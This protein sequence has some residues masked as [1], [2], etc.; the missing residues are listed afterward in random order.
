M[1]NNLY[2]FYRSKEWESF[3]KVVIAERV[4]EDGFVYD[5]VTGKPIVKAY[6]IILH[7]KIE[8]TEENIFDFSISLNPDNIMIVSHKTH[9]LIHNK[10]GYGMREVFLIYGAPL[11]GKSSFVNENKLEGDMVIDMD[12]LWEAV[13]GCNRYVKPNRL[14]S[15][16]FRLRDDLIDMVKYRFGKWS[17]AYVI[18]GYPLQ[19]ERE[20]IC[21][22]LGAREILIEATEAECLER[23]QND[24]D[25]KSIEGY[26]NYIREWFRMYAPGVP[27][28]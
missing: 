24:E 3:R 5:E 26:E 11:S 23:L 4:K 6:D 7:H 13:S 28:E 17:N 9:N 27:Q 16:V 21:K 8:L 1:F 18:G 20:R 12:S 2:E 15:V 10:L 19:S 25:R 22:D 14:K